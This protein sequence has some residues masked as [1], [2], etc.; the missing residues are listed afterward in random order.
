MNK[1]PFERIL[2]FYRFECGGTVRILINGDVDTLKAIEMAE[3]IIGLKREEIA[4]MKSGEHPLA[5][6]DGV[7][8]RE[9]HG[10]SEF[11]FGSKTKGECDVV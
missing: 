3:I 1:Q 8:A 11:D 5:G 2:G 10:L 4:M 7:H 9:G 6:S